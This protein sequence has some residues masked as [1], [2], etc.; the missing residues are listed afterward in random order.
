MEMGRRVS[1]TW[2]MFGISLSH[3]MTNSRTLIKLKREVFESCIFPVITYGV[4][5]MNSSKQSANRLRVCQRTI[6]RA[7][8]GITLRDKM[9]RKV[10]RGRTAV[11]DVIE[12]TARKKWRWAGHLARDDLNWT[13]TILQW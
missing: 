1:L 12:G 6:E 11:R 2:A 5:T 3:I 7:M 8:Q 9:R 10:I 13:K 4:E